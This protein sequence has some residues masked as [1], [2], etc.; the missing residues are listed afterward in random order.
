MQFTQR[1]E[2]KREEKK[3]TSAIKH[4][5]SPQN[6][7]FNG[8]LKDLEAKKKVSKASKFTDS[9]NP[10]FPVKINSRGFFDVEYYSR[11]S[12]SLHYQA[13]KFNLTSKGNLKPYVEKS[14]V[15]DKLEKQ[16]EESQVKNTKNDTFITGN[17]D[18]SPLKRQVSLR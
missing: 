14:T 13:P 15:T 18:Q 11:P 7:F 17:R 5:H 1:A 6:N 2:K 4:S 10:F 9:K 3:L 8:L 12:N 16:L